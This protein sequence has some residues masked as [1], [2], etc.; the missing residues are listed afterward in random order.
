MTFV[1]VFPLLVTAAVIQICNGYRI[2][3]IYPFQGRSHFMVLNQLFKGLARKGHQVDL[4]SVLPLEE[5]HPNYTRIIEL[6]NNIAIFMEALRS[7][8]SQS[9]SRNIPLMLGKVGYKLCESMEAPEFLDLVRNPPKDIPYDVI[10]TQTLCYP[11]FTILGYLWN[12]PVVVISTTSLYPWMH[13]MIGNPD[14]TAISPNNLI[15]IPEGN[16]FWTRL[17]NTYLFYYIK[18]LYFYYTSNQDHL[19]QKLFGPNVPSIREL[20]QN[21]SLILMNTYFPLNGIK[22]MTTGLVE[23]GGLH[24]QNDGP[25]LPDNLKKWLDKSKDGVVYFT[26]G[27][28][29]RIETLAV[30]KVEIIFKSLEK[31]APKQVLIRIEKPDELNVTIPKNFHHLLWMPQE[32]ILQHPNV[33]AFITH[34]GLLGTQESIYYGV[35]MICLPLVVDQWTNANSYVS[36]K[37]AITLDITKV[38]EDE[39]DF[40]LGEILNNSIYRENVKRLSGLFRDRPQSAMDTAAFW[41]EFV[42]RNGK[43][44]LRSPAMDLTW[45]QLALLDVHA[46]AIAGILTTVHITILI[47]KTFV[48]LIYLQKKKLVVLHNKKKLL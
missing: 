8:N 48:R 4:I 40:A 44:S 15:S 6:P 39:F 9:L 33:K 47:L 35:P 46:I 3:G 26:L 36:K 12:I 1:K 20:E 29:F 24:I 34:G 18:L 11:C 41:I 30:E 31:I 27:S 45:W 16:N 21:I 37:I 13:G 19:L 10:I 32:K 2:L 7:E 22:P 43:D 14:N 17:V 38:T 42:I 25:D 23:V 28:M 5:N